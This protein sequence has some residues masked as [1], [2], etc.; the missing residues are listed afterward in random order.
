M[1]FIMNIIRDWINQKILGKIII[2]KVKNNQFIDK[3]FLVD[4]SNI[5]NKFVINVNFIFLIQFLKFFLSILI[6]IN[7]L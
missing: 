2:G 3:L 6:L 5:S 4:G 1:G 7:R